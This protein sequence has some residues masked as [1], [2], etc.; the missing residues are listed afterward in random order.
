MQISIAA[1]TQKEDLGQFEIV[2]ISK[3]DL[4]KYT[5]GMTLIPTGTFIMGNTDRHIFATKKDTN[6]LFSNNEARVVKVAS[7]YMS[8]HEVTNAEYRKFTNWVRDSIARRYLVKEDVEI[9][10]KSYKAEINE[11]IIYS[12]YNHDDKKTCFLNWKLEIPWN[13]NSEEDYFDDVTKALKPLYLPTLER[14]YRRKEFDTRKLI[15]QNE[16]GEDKISVYPDTSVWINDNTSPYNE[17]YNKNY[18]WHPKYDNYPVVGITWRQA[19]AYCNWLT[20]RL[21]L[22]IKK[23]NILLPSYRLPTEAEWEYAAV[24]GAGKYNTDTITNKIYYSSLFPWSYNTVID[25]KGNYPANFGK[26]ISQNG[27]EIKPYSEGILEKKKKE[28]NL[29]YTT[30]VKS[31]SA[32]KLKLYDMGGNVAEWCIDI[33]HVKPYFLKVNANDSL[34]TA[35][36]KIIKRYLYENSTYK[37]I[38]IKN[39]ADSTLLNMYLLHFCYGKGVNTNEIKYSNSD[40]YIFNKDSICSIIKNFSSHKNGIYDKEDVLNNV[41]Y[42]KERIVIKKTHLEKIINDFL[43]NLATK[44][45]HNAKTLANNKYLKIVKGGSWADSPIYLMCGSKEVFP[46]NKSSAKIGFRVV[47]PNVGSPP[48]F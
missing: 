35:I 38:K 11:D 23:T 22:S 6:L 26:I 33:T 3:K 4:K 12:G 5:K 2:K 42:E 40:N 30:P 47:I 48:G 44:E 19:N 32:N 37:Y 10:N 34:Q 28:S 13:M 27:F 9:D 18:F 21:L 24:R 17:E 1:F 29:D 25:S 41:L 8:N 46:Q 43:I 7:F 45:I 15:Y 31:F 36:N 20:N 16:F 39:A 14:F